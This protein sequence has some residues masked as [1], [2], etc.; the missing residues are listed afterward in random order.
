M[1]A[2]A[3]KFFEL[4]KQGLHAL[5]EILLAPNILFFLGWFTVVLL[6]ASTLLFVWNRIFV[7]AEISKL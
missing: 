2:Y 4:I 1:K 3:M 6:L 7:E 5:E